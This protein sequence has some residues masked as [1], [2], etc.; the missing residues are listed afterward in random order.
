MEVRG[1]AAFVTGAGSGIGR[2][3][4]LALARAGCHVLCSDLNSES[5]ATT[6]ASCRLSGVQVAFR[7][8]DAGDKAALHAAIDWGE[9]WAR[10]CGCAGVSI[11]V[12][13][14]GILTLGG[15]DAADE[16]WRRA[17]A[18][19]TMQCVHAADRIVPLMAGR[20]GGSFV[21]VASAAGLLT[22]HGALPYAVSKAAAV[23][24]ARWIAISHGAA[25]SGNVRVSCVCP[26]AVATGM[27]RGADPRR[28]LHAASTMSGADGVLD[29]DAVAAAILD[30]IAS[31]RFLVLPHPSVA[32]YITFAAA[33]PERWIAR[34][35]QLKAAFESARPQAAHGTGPSRAR[36]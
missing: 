17:F 5:A 12:A 25:D 1:R 7:A 29:A 34:M 4:C 8:V 22:Q 27:T 33:K 2:A 3:L 19:N 11:F 6:A 30:G 28:D 20:G 23:A 35:Q 21:V 9:E 10:G 31:G 26:Q 14:A 32:K 18:V 15:L 36:L 24:V 13:N 16:V